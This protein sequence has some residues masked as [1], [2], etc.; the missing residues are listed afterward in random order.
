MPSWRCARIDERL[1]D[2]IERL[3]PY[4][5]GNPEPVF[6]ARDVRVRDAASSARRT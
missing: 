6:L 4:G 3:E 1:L 5:M 2:D